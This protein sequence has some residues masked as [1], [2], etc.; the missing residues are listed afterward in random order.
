MAFQ[1]A[2]WHCEFSGTVWLNESDANPPEGDTKPP[3]DDNP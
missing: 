3:G 2:R 1:L